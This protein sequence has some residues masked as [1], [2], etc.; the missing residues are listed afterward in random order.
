MAS[1]II[2]GPAL[3]RYEGVL[4]EVGSYTGPCPLNKDWSPRANIPA[5]FWPMWERFDALTDEDKL[6]C[7]VE[8]GGCRR[9]G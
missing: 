9:L 1:G 8:A 5:A 2:C 4:F 3:Y 6:A 7:Q